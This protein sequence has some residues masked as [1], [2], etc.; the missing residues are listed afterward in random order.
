[1]MTVTINDDGHEEWWRPQLM[2]MIAKNDDNHE[3][4]RSLRMMMITK[5][6]LYEGG[7]KK[8]EDFFNEFFYRCFKDK[9]FKLVV[10]L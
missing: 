2:K 1:M 3:W 9:L 5:K 7:R 4:W 10:S 8:T 6:S